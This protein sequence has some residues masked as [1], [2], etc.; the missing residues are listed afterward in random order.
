MF[1]N[2]LYKINEFSAGTETISAV[3]SIDPDHEIFEGHF[4]DRPVTPGVV[5]LQMV[6]ELLEKHFSK[7]ITLKSMRTCKFIQV[8]NPRETPQIN[9]HIKFR[10]DEFLD[11]TA[12][13]SYQGT[14]YFKAQVSYI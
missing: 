1:L 8:L 13:G 3:L 12:T 14:T 5:Q 7:N 4:P 11:V 6:T 9:I 2:S 10:R